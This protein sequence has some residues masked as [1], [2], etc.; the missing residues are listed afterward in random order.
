MKRKNR[1]PLWRFISNILRIFVRK[2]KFI[3][4]GEEFSDQSLYLSNH[5]GAKVPL[6]LELYFPKEFNVLL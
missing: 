1:H 6:A 5:V 2:P 4:L 3:F